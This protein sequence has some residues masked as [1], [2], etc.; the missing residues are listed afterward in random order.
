MTKKLNGKVAV[1]TGGSG[2]IG[3]AVAA[4]FVEEGARVFITGRN[5]KSLEEAKARLGAAVTAI[6]GD[7]GSLEDL[8]RL[9]GAVKS[10][11][12]SIDA[13][14]ANAGANAQTTLADTTPE[15]LDHILNL[16]VRGT[17]FTVQKALPLLAQGGSVV[18]VSSAVQT[19][20]LAGYGAYAASKAAIRS[21]ARTWASELK[22]RGI[23]VNSLSPGGTDTP[24]LIDGATAEAAD[25]QRRQYG[26][27]IPLG[28]LAKPEEIASA[29]LFLAS[30][31]SSFATGIDL[32]V[33]GG[34]SQL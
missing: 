29:A 17:L 20:G 13:L 15:Q 34:F 11:A 7:A 25:Q 22:D 21:F 3:F 19:K 10:E 4:R 24:F 2:G 18:L 9:Y 1:V 8:D 30:N 32:V 31:E 27:W 6:S 28:R 12:G 5:Q 14:V 23:R 33:D 16:N 26:T